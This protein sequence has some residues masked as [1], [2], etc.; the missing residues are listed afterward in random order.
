GV[1]DGGYGLARPTGNDGRAIEAGAHAYCARNGRY[2]PLTRW[3]IEEGAL[4]GRIELPIQVGTVGG[5]VKAN[6]LI[7]V[8]LRTMGNPGARKLAG[9]MAAVGLAQ[10]V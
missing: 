3:W 8:L 2:E 10:D 1:M 4:L 7:P 6:P 5:A 9:I